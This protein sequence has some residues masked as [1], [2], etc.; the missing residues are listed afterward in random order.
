[1]KINKILLSLGMVALVAAGAEARSEKRGVCAK[2]TYAGEIEQIEKGSC[3]WYNWGNTPSAGYQYQ[4]QNYESSMDFCPMTWNRSYS[5]E[6][7]RKYCKEHPEVKYLLGF[8]EPNFTNQANLTPAQAAEAWPAVVALARELGL[9]IVA[10]ALNYSSNPQ[11]STP[12]K[13]MDEFVKLVGLDAFDYTALHNYGGFGLMKSTA[14]EFY[15]KYGKQVWVTE[16]CYWPGGAGNVYVAPETQISSMVECVEWLESSECIYRYSWFMAQGVS[17]GNNQPNYGLL[18]TT[19]DEDKNIINTLTE[20]G[21]VYTYLWEYDPEYYH[22]VG[23]FVA[24]TDY[25]ARNVAGIGSG[26]NPDAPKPI[27]IKQFNGGATLDYQFDVPEAGDY[28]LELVVSGMGEPTRFDPMMSIC[29]VDANGKATKLCAARRFTLSN[30]DE[31]YNTELFK[32]T[33]PAGKQTLRLKDEAPYQ[34]SGIRISALRLSS[35]A[36]IDAVNVESDKADAPVDVYNTQ[37]M[38]V[39]SAV[40]PGEATKG[41]PAGIYLVGSRKVLVK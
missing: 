7:I 27:E 35:V 2:F 33:L 12:A 16:W 21:K 32:V 10:P 22:P 15:A 19:V 30:S 23:Q 34:P 17:D 37:G 1:M 25:H 39:R 20:Q 24:A 18:K 29:S 40:A 8:N 11:Y 36:G 41:L 14:E 31:N 4:V 28:N 9:K 5:A 3:W 6:N 13:W 38:R 26:A